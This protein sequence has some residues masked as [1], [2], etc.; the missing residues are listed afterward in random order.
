MSSQ[1]WKLH[2]EYGRY[3]VLGR[4]NYSHTKQM[5]NRCMD[6]AGSLVGN[7]LRHFTSD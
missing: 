5:V 6:R 1:L 4:L 3:Y 2:A 7:Y